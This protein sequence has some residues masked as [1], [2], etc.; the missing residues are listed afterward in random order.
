[1]GKKGTGKGMPEEFK[2][3][4]NSIERRIDIESKQDPGLLHRLEGIN[5]DQSTLGSLLTPSFTYSKNK[6]ELE[7]GFTC[8]STDFMMPYVYKKVDDTIQSYKETF[9]KKLGRLELVLDKDDTGPVWFHKRITGRVKAGS[10]TLD[11]FKVTYLNSNNAD[12]GQLGITI[13]D[14]LIKKGGGLAETLFNSL[15]EEII[16][17]RDRLEDLMECGG[18]DDDYEADE[19][20]TRNSSTGETSFSYDESAMALNQLGL[21]VYHGTENFG[22]VGG[23]EKLK[24]SIKRDALYPLLHREVYKELEKNT[25]VHGSSSPAGAILFY[26][27]S[28]TGKTLMAR[29][30]ANEEKIHLVYLPLAKIFS[31]WMNQSSEKLGKAFDAVE[32]YNRNNGKTIL[33]IDEVD[34]IGSRST[35]DGAAAMDDRRVVD[36]F[37]T[38]L[39]GFNSNAE[40]GNLIVIGSTNHHM[41]L[42]KAIRSRFGS[43]IYFPLPSKDDRAKI[44]ALYAKQLSPDELNSVASATDGFSGRDI[45]NV[46]K[47]ALRHAGQ[48]IIEKHSSYKAP[49]LPYYMEAIKEISSKVKTTQTGEF[50]SAYS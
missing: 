6:A 5:V 43:E 14:E 46:A 33:F 17:D 35:E 38:R 36:M 25:E 34:S 48:D 13:K 16:L 19:N 32:A 2:K 30:I 18:D 42:D 31:M 37:L 26:G 11:L 45:K 23:Y 20:G 50:A 4:K 24:D 40:K 22:Y 15:W 21:Q 49:P 28:G 39:D 27:P 12:F 7:I 44:M 10:K 47:K 29:V 41:A 3:L 8:D 1:M 9:S